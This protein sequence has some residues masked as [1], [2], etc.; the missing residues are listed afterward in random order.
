MNPLE[1]YKRGHSKNSEEKISV[2]TGTFREEIN[3][4][5]LKITKVQPLVIVAYRTA[6]HHDLPRIPHM[7]QAKTWVTFLS[8]TAKIN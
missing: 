6:F 5:K 7:T 4:K 2:D 3:Q 1:L 8:T